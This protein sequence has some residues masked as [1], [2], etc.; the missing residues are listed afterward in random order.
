MFKNL[1]SN[2]ILSVSLHMMIFCMKRG[3][4]SWKLYREQVFGAL[5]VYHD[6]IPQDFNEQYE[7]QWID[8][9]WHI[10]DVAI[11]AFWKERE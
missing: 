3:D 6:I 1:Y 5:S 11:E 2:P 8:T 4:S 7:S 9:L 10:C